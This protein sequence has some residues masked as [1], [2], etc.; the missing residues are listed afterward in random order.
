MNRSNT[1]DKHLQKHDLPGDIA[2]K[3]PGENNQVNTPVSFNPDY[4]LVFPPSF[5]LGKCLD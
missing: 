2:D 4:L 3:L 5:P 1:P